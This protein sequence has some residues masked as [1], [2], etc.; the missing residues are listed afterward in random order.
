M[1]SYRPKVSLKNLKLKILK[2]A[3]LT[4][5][6]LSLY[7]E[8]LKTRSSIFANDTERLNSRFYIE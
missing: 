4:L 3:Y 6:V 2:I 5:K 8:L 1:N 7:K